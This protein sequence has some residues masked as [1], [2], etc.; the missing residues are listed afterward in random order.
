MTFRGFRIRWVNFCV[1]RLYEGTKAKNFEKKRKL[2]NSIG[3]S[4]GEGTKVVGPLYCSGTLI[5]GKNCW[6]GRNLTVN[7]N[8]TVFIGD[9]CDVAPD[10]VFQTGTHRVGDE[11]RR[12]GEGLTQNITVGN[13]CWLGVRSTVLGGVTISDGS[14]VAACALVNKDVRENTLIGGVPAHEIRRLGDD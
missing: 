14:V 8:G 6:L 5:V 9:R 11:N 4:I 13:G 2:L 1:N 12:A 3:H 10:V 7:G